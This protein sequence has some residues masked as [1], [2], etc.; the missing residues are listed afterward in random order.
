MRNRK[1]TG[2][3]LIELLVVVVLAVVM[4][5]ATVFNF[6]SVLKKS[7]LE[8]HI[9]SLAASIKMSRTMAMSEGER[10]IIVVV[11]AHQPAQNLGDGRSLHYLAFLDQNKNNVYDNG[12][13]VLDRG[14]WDT[15]SVEENSLPF[16]Y[17]LGLV[18]AHYF[19]F[20]PQGT[21]PMPPDLTEDPEVRITYA[22]DEPE[23]RL[24]IISYLG[25]VEVVRVK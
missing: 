19:L 14:D 15:I 10:A 9:E 3:T 25:A 8:S 17:N 13:R 1:Q 11:D 5:I 24:N 7:K 21:A 16:D 6:A 12:E 18:Q 4:L 22:G 2:W 23:Y 20:M